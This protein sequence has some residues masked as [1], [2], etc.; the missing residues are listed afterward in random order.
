MVR[1]T[2]SLDAPAGEDGESR[3]GAFIRDETIPSPWDALLKRSLDEHARRALASL[4]PREE[5]IL[6]KRFGVGQS[7]DHTLEEIG[8]ELKVTRERIRQIESKALRKL[9]HPVRSNKLKTFS[10]N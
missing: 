3:I 10:D 2:L 9:T 6:R 1:D 5:K 8:K 4:S 7:S